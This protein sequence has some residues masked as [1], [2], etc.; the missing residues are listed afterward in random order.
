LKTPAIHTA[1]IPED[2]FKVN[3]KAEPVKPVSQMAQLISGF[4]P[5]DSA[6][7]QNVFTVI[8]SGNVSI[9]STLVNLNGLAPESNLKGKSFFVSKSSVIGPN[10]RVELADGSMV[11]A[12]VLSRDDASDLVLLQISQEITGGIRLN[13]V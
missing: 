9:L 5:Q 13:S 7:K 6:F 4:E 2:K 12:K 10:P 1:F 8:D 3:K 11:S